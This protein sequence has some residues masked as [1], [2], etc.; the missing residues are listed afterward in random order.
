MG[1]VFVHALPFHLGE[2][3]FFSIDTRLGENLAARRDDEALA[4]EFDP[5]ATRRRFV[6]RPD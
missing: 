5:I 3:G 6:A 4:P 2:D 1:T